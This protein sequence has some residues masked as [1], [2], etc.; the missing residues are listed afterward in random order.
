MFTTA[1]LFAS[2]MVVGQAEE[3]PNPLQ[4]F[5][6]DFRGHWVAEWIADKN[7]PN[8]QIKKGDK[9][10]TIVTIDWGLNKAI[11]ET[12]LQIGPA[13]VELEANFKGIFAWDPKSEQIVL[14]WFR[15]DGTVGTSTCVKEGDVWV[16]QWKSVNRNCEESSSKSTV[17]M[18]DSNKTHIHHRTERIEAGQSLDD[19]ELIFKRS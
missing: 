12:E 19:D 13:D 6:D 2:A 14:R 17:E 3:E 7:S 4:E 5:A 9:G 15:A 1:L 18:A 10:K 16:W 11:L 8:G